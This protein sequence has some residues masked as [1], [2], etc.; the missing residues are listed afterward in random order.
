MLHCTERKS[1]NMFNIF[2]VC[3]EA[4]QFVSHDMGNSVLAFV[5]GVQLYSLSH[6]F[7]LPLIWKYNKSNEMQE[8]ALGQN[9]SQGLQMRIGQ[10]K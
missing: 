3:V 8:D 2:L 10:I 9:F 5:L 1:T 6:F 7:V 4:A